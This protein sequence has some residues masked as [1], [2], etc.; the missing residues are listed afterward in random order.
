M[1]QGPYS[2]SPPFGGEREYSSGQLA[3]RARVGEVL[4]RDAH[5]LVLAALGLAQVDVLRDVLRRRHADGPAR[6]VDLGGAQRLVEVGLV[7][8]LTLHGLQADGQKLRGVVALYGIDV[9][10]APGLVAEGLA[11]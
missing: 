11:E 6:A 4:H 2:L 9:G 5:H 8:D 1:W 3:A 10:L 7:L